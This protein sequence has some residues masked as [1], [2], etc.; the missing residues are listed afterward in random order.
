M[1]KVLLGLLLA[2]FC[3]S[4]GA[5]W[6]K[7]S[8]GRD[9]ARYLDPSS[10]RITGDMVKVM[11]MV[12][13]KTAQWPSEDAPILSLM[14]Q[15]EYDCKEYRLRILYAAMYSRNLGKGTNVFSDNKPHEWTPVI[16]DSPGANEWKVICG[17]R[18]NQTGI[19]G[20]VNKA[21]DFFR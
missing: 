2:G 3:Q 14:R 15:T 8:E 9:A 10:V 16:P 5:E 12:D 19:K 21:K 7:M 18:D 11:F 17:Y 13:Y 4:V 6:V 1:R 20:Y